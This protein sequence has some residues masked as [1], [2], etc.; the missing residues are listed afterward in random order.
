MKSLIKTLPLCIATT[1]LV[2]GCAQ[3]PI[4]S[5]A[6]T[7]PMAPAL[8]GAYAVNEKLKQTEILAAGKVDGP[9]DIDVDQY[10]RIYGANVDGRIVRIQKDHAGNESIKTFAETGGRPLG[11]HFDAEGNLI[12]CDAIKGLLSISPKGEV[13]TLLT[14]VD[15]LPFAF[16]DDVDIAKDGTI[17]FTDASSKYGIKQYKFDLMEAKPYGRLISYQPKTGETKVLLDNLYF[18]NGAALSENEDFILVVE[19]ARYRVKRYWLKGDK[20]GTSDI[21]IDNLPGF[22][23]GI[24]SNKK[25]TFWLAVPST[26]KADMDFLHQYPSLKNTIAR[27]PE[28]M[29]PKPIKYGFVLGLNEQGEVIHNLQ[30]PDG[31][32]VHTITSVE[33][34]DGY[35]YLGSL[36]NDRIGRLPLSELE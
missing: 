13:I 9:E 21:F 19:T 23:D 30:E 26:R 15:D 12:V 2:Q 22:P 17:Y 29:L 20:A 32:V 35:I 34:K 10:G 24:S 3:A 31:D 4:D 27:L 11:I 7:P 8:D 28:S 25:G 1:I 33:E 16:T 36:T 18:A 5:V 14:E 6:Y